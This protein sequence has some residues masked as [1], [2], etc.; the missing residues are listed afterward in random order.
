MQQHHLMG[1]RTVEK[2]SGDAFAFLFFHTSFS[3][4]SHL[5]HTTT[6]ALHFL[7]CIF[8]FTLSHAPPQH[9]AGRIPPGALSC[10]F[11]WRFWFWHAAWCVHAWHGSVA[12]VLACMRGMRA[13]WTW[14]VG[15]SWFLSL[16]LCARWQRMPFLFLYRCAPGG[17]F[18]RA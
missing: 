11:A 6:L 1:G 8:L 16:C 13:G 5:S 2:N 7:L 18:W 17:C 10:A 3:P 15:T 12:C 14:D 9:C 4:L